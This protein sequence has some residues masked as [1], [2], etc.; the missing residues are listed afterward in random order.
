MMLETKNE[1]IHFEDKFKSKDYLFL[2]KYERD[3][4]TPA[5]LKS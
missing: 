4:K 2:G 5:D 1:I 3:G